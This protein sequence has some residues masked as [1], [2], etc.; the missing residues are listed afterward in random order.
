MLQIIPNIIRFSVTRSRF[1]FIL[2]W[3]FSQSLLLLFQCILS[4]LFCYARWYYCCT[5]C[6]FFDV[7]WSL[8]DDEDDDDIAFICDVVL[9]CASLDVWVYQPSLSRTCVM[10]TNTDHYAKCTNADIWI[11]IASL[12]TKMIFFFFLEMITNFQ[13]YIL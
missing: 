8:G 9:M 13:L 4:L 12:L 10:H 11:L 5:E 7:L 6:G 1:M 2:P 3:N